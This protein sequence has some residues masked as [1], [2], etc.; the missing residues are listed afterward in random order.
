MVVQDEVVP[1]EFQ[2]PRWRKHTYKW[3]VAKLQ[4]RTFYASRS[5]SSAVSPSRAEE[6]VEH[7]TAD[8]TGTDLQGPQAP[9]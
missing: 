8:S 4:Q 3:S 6:A 2:S 1:L 5:L 7:E 9:P